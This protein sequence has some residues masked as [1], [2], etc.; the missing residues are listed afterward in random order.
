[1]SH[2]S[3]YSALDQID[4]SNVSRLEVAWTFPVTGTVIFNPLVVDG[5]MYLQ[6]S[7]ST[8]AAVAAATRKEIWRT[9]TQGPIGA[10]GMNYWESPDRSDR[11]L[12]FIAGGYLMAINAQTGDAIAGF[13]DNGRVDLRIALDRPAAQPL[14]TG[15][16]GRIFENTMIV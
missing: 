14:H 9:Q 15:N 3:Q 12:L 10:R 7:A 4:K 1:G 13:G 8:L 11:R 6:A 2:S 5:V 16:P